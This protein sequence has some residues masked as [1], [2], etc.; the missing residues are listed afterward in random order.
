MHSPAVLM[1]SLE[2][3]F[4][5]VD[6]ASIQCFLPPAPAAD[7]CLTAFFETVFATLRRY[8]FDR[9]L[10]LSALQASGQ[11]TCHGVGAQFVLGGGSDGRRRLAL[12]LD[13]CESLAESMGEEEEDEE[14]R[15]QANGI[16]LSVLELLNATV[17]LPGTAPLLQEG[18]GTA[19]RVVLHVLSTC[20]PAAAPSSTEF[21][22][23]TECLRFLLAAASLHDPLSLVVGE[24]GSLLLLSMVQNNLE[25]SAVV[26]MIF[27]LFGRLVFLKP[28]LM[29]FVQHRGIQTLLSAC[30]EHRDDDSLVCSAVT[31]LGNI[32]SAD[33]DCALLV[34][35]AGAEVAV[36]AVQNRKCFQ[37]TSDFPALHAAARSTL[38][39]L[40]V[41]RRAK[42]R[43]GTKTSVG[44]LLS[45]VGQD[46]DTVVNS[47]QDRVKK[48]CLDLDR[49]DPLLPAYR[50]ALKSGQNV[51]DYVKGTPFARKL[52][53]TGDCAHLVLKEDTNNIKKLGRRIKLSN[54][55]EVTSGYG[56]GHYKAGLFGGKKTKA[57]V[58]RCL[59]MSPTDKAGPTDAIT[60][61]FSNGTDRDKWLDVLGAL[62][63]A[64]ATCPHFLQE[65]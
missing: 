43:E 13:L 8:D 38:L 32:V 42:D 37:P 15:E 49:D 28:N 65:L 39:G 59:Y 52:W 36:E 6:A 58:E 50:S 61:E 41:R 16:L 10:V 34:L 24:R 14:C 47:E 26:A 12:L 33:Q 54:L 23:L 46:V 51:T 3:A 30:E 20:S 4:N 45:R 19:V 29:S 9:S 57:R 17:E 48:S 25:E 63:L 7:S 56:P 2:V 64:A 53:L 44:T 11:L 60:L 1:T 22:L 18:G 5:L 40:S 27:Q 55:A 35:E 62:L 21:L 31:T